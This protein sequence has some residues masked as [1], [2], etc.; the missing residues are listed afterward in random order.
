MAIRP[1]TL[2][3]SLKSQKSSQEPHVRWNWYLIW[4]FLK[5][6]LDCVYIC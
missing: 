2:L 6:R 4:A 1:L 3:D 5:T